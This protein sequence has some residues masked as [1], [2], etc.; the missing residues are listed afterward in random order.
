M[1]SN[2]KGYAMP[3][4]LLVMLALVLL[5]TAL[6]HFGTAE[7]RQVSRQE[8][9]AK[10]HYLARSGLSVTEKMLEERT[11]ILGEDEEVFYLYGSI[12]ND[13]SGAFEWKF[14]E[15]EDVL[16]DDEDIEVVVEWEG[17]EKGYGSGVITSY[18]NYLE[19]KETIK[20]NFEFYTGIDGDTANW[21][22]QGG[23]QQEGRL[24]SGNVKEEWEVP[25]SFTNENEDED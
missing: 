24:R 19:V 6:W 3:L 23:G 2:E 15:E 22:H 8:H 1:I 11:G 21:M 9:R 13:D 25:V 10:A 14:R 20:R 4:V 17:I 16:A 7:T 12:E 5:S 18:G